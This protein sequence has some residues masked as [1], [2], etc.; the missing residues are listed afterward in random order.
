MRPVISG[1]NKH[2]LPVYN[3]PMI[4]YSLSVL[5]LCKFREIILVCDP[6]SKKIYENIFLGG[7]HLGMKINIVVQKEANGIPE[8][9]LLS[10]NI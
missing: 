2:F 8:V 7:R 6:S 9:F 10:K 3:K 5:M 1:I 4:Y